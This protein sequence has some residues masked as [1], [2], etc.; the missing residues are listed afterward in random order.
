MNATYDC[1]DVEAEAVQDGGV[2]VV[3]DMTRAGMV[4]VAVVL[5]VVPGWGHGG[6]GEHDEDLPMLGMLLCVD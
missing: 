3:S 6:S 1:D 2:E 4:V 5:E